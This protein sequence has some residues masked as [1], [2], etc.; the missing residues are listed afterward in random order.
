MRK[1]TKFVT[2]EPQ[3]EHSV[4]LFASLSQL[5]VDSVSR[6]NLKR[7]FRLSGDSRKFTVL[8]RFLTDSMV[9]HTINN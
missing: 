1:S 2:V 4:R 3:H 7:Q 5:Q 9:E 8:E 6:V